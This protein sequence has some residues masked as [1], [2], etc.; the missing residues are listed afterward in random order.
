MIK[1]GPMI[2]G[3]REM[4]DDEIFSQPLKLLIIMT[5]AYL[6]GFHLGRY[7]KKAVIENAH[8]IFYRSIQK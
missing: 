1:F 5:K 7:R 3:M 4:S 8:H 6:T 2:E